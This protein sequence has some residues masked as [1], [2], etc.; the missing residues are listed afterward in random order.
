LAPKFA[1]IATARERWPHGLDLPR[2]RH[3]TGYL[4]VVLSGGFEEAGDCGRR[5]VRAGDVNCHGPFDAHCDRFLADG[6]ETINFD[7]PDW[8]DH[9][10]AFCRVY[11][12]DLIARTAERDY[13]AARESLLSM[14]EP[15]RCAARDWPDE[16]A[17]DIR[18]HPD[19]CLTEWAESRAMA[20][21]SVSRGFRRVYEISP[22]AFRAQM[23]V[24]RAWRGLVN[25]DLPLATVAQ[26]N[27][28]ADQAHMTRAVT[29]LTGQRPSQWRR[30]GLSRFKT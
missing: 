17:I 1:P 26:D 13:V 7:L 12:P 8:A 29:M 11:D 19:L 14:L 9:P 28:F 6:A 30:L 5:I 25:S 18:R 21:A 3:E 16:L 20:P 2:H 27:G 4:C 15:V 23:R 24:R 22:I 10:A